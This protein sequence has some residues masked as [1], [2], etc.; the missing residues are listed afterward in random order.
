MEGM[1]GADGAL[2]LRILLEDLAEAAGRQ[3]GKGKGK[4]GETNDAALSLSLWKEELLATRQKSMDRRMALSASD[5]IAT[6][7][8]AICQIER[9]ERMAQ[10]DREMALA[11]SRGQAPPT[12][13]PSKEDNTKIH[14]TSDFEDLDPISQVLSS[15]MSELSIE[16]ESRA[17]G[18]PGPSSGRPLFARL[19]KCVSCLDQIPASESLD[20]P[21][22]HV[23][24]EICMQQ[25]FL[26][27]TRDEG[28]YPPR[29]CGM[30]VPA[31][32][33]LRLLSY[34]ELR[35]F[36]EKG[37]ECSTTDRTY[38]A[39]P[40]CSTFIPSWSI[41][42]ELATCPRCQKIT[43]TLCKSLEHPFKDCPC[44][45][46][47]QK[48]LKLAKAEGWRRCFNCRTMVQLSRGCNHMI[49]R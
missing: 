30:T 23:Y 19:V 6:D 5:A 31:G 32:I 35:E 1:D 11:V 42:D 39:D 2:A 12:S 20:S 37:I 38:C 24:C 40:K 27:A 29:C 47:L 10:A 34:Q 28:L 21:C 41:S 17:L 15:L 14:E 48:V 18:E 9:S 8:N 46:S 33:A 36:A 45:E 16:S 49:C 26:N 25:L 13:S 4:E 7:Q 22:G 44:D 43:H 3:N